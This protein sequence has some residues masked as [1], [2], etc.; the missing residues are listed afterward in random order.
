M[1]FDLLTLK[2]VGNISRGTDDL[3]A[4]CGACMTFCCRVIG[5]HASSLGIG[6]LMFLTYINELVFIL[7]KHNIKVKLFADDVKNVH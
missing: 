3:P 7:E 4:N 5:K 1:T 2:L 6:P